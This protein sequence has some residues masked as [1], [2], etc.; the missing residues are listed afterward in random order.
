[1]TLPRNTL[2]L[3]LLFSFAVYGTTACGASPKNVA[4]PSNTGNGNSGGGGSGHITIDTKNET[5][6]GKYKTGIKHDDAMK[7]DGAKADD[8]SVDF[9]DGQV[10]LAFSDAHPEACEVLVRAKGAATTEGPK[11]GDPIEVWS[12]A[13]G[14]TTME[15]ATGDTVFANN[16][17]IAVTLDDDKKLVVGVR[18]GGC[19]E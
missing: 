14:A 17:H 6:N 7:L 1:M 16:Q 3:S 9:L 8:S 13:F 10:V 4:S 2:A 18:L 5:V 19:P 15:E 12:K 11:V